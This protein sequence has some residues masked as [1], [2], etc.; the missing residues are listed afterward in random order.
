MK[1]FPQQT[2]GA[3]FLSQRRYAL[4]ADMP[5]VGKTGASIMA[6]DW[7]MDASI[8]VVTEVRKVFRRRSAAV[9]AAAAAPAAPAAA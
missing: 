9:L 7:A 1:P 5:R 2:D 8:I 3:R 6:A 4:L